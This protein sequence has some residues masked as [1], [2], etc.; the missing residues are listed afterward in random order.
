M[1][2]WLNIAPH[3]NKEGFKFH[4]YNTPA[5]S[6]KKQTERT[7]L[8]ILTGTWACL[9]RY[10]AGLLPS[11]AAPFAERLETCELISEFKS[12]SKGAWVLEVAR[13]CED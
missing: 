2:K 10:L 12:L 11:A 6:P 8:L 7:S 13:V 3:L 5:Q 4:R 1:S 9:Y